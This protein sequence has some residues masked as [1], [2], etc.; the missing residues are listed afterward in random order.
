MVCWYWPS[1]NAHTVPFPPSQWYL[2]SLDSSLPL[3]EALIDEADALV[4][5]KGMITLL[6]HRKALPGEAVDPVAY[7]GELNERELSGQRAQPKQ[8]GKGKGKEAGGKGKDRSKGGAAGEGTEGEAAEAAGGGR[9]LPRWR[10]ALL[11]DEAG[12]GLLRLCNWAECEANSLTK[13][14]MGMALHKEKVGRGR[15]AVCVFAKMARWGCRA[16]RLS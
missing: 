10:T 8:G 6:S 13:A 5:L 7:L 3:P 14:I 16:A 15:L 9:Q 12:K 4:V 2:E 11:E 1:A